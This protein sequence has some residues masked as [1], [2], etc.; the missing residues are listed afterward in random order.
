MQIISFMLTVLPL[1]CYVEQN[2]IISILK[3]ETLH[4]QQ[5][6]ITLA[7]TFYL[8]K[9]T[10]FVV[11]YLILTL[12]PCTSYAIRSQFNCANPFDCIV[13]CKNDNFTISLAFCKL[14]LK[15]TKTIF[16]LWSSWIISCRTT[17]PS[18]TCHRGI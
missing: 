11:I 8:I 2:Y 4:P 5:H 1:S 13:C 15:I 18:R 17:S 12:S 14:I 9:I 7:Q 16:L 6:R 3:D 10:T